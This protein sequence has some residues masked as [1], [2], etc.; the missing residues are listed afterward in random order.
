MKKRVTAVLLLLVLVLSLATSAMA[1]SV[2]PTAKL[3]G[4]PSTVARGK[5]V[6]FVFRLDSKDYAAKKDVYRSKLI[7]WI[8][9]GS[10][11]TGNAVWVWTGKQY[12]HLRV[13]FAKKAP[14][15]KY[16]LSYTT[17]Y[18]TSGTASWRKVKTQTQAFT[19]K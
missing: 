12:Y 14:T 17:Y 8:S 4:S 18:R 3:T 16:K 13:K 1:A 10:Q 15:G 19:V 6:R 9:K 5:M 2:K 7:T 11:R